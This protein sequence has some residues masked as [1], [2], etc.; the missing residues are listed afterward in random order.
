MRARR[1]SAKSPRMTEELQMRIE[2]FAERHVN[3]SYMDIASRFGVSTGRV[4]EALS[5]KR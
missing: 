3:Y 1:A 4:S 2:E 5:G